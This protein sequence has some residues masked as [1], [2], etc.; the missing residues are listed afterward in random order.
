M[1]DCGENADQTEQP[2]RR[3]V[4][5]RRNPWG[6]MKWI[7]YSIHGVNFHEVNFHE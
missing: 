6:L 4:R 2:S 7:G 3:N 1:L 5:L